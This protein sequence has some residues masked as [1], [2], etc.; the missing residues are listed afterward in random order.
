MDNASIL[1]LTYNDFGLTYNNFSANHLDYYSLQNYI[2]KYNTPAYSGLTFKGL[3]IQNFDALEE[4]DNEDIEALEEFT[5][6]KTYLIKYDENSGTFIGN[7]IPFDN[8]TS[9]DMV[10]AEFEISNPTE[11]VATQNASGE[12]IVVYNSGS[13]YAQLYYNWCFYEN[14]NG[15]ETFEHIEGTT[16]QDQSLNLASLSY[17]SGTYDVVCLV[18]SHIFQG[19]KYVKTIIDDEIGFEITPVFA[20]SEI[21]VVASAVNGNVITPYQVVIN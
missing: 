4:L 18:Y 8:F 6:G 10:F 16:L 19:F 15:N 2:Q 1:T 3:Y 17:E 9:L 20:A 14:N 12:I 11:E 5:P 7:G 21:I 13:Q